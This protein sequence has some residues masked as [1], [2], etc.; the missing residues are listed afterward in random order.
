LH[1]TDGQIT[2]LFLDAVPREE[3]VDG[4]WAAYRAVGLDKTTVRKL[5][6]Q[7]L[8][9]S[10]AGNV[11][12]VVRG[13]AKV[14]LA[15]IIDGAIDVQ[16]EWLAAGIERPVELPEQSIEPVT[17]PIGDDETLEN[18][19][20]REYRGPLTPDMLRESLRRYKKGVVGGA[21]GFMGFSG[22]GRESMGGRMGGRKLFR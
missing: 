22:D 19:I 16:K 1:E 6:N 4:R 7:T 10:V 13:Y 20:A 9:Q 15:E 2:S 3:G 8:S 17:E 18:K 21:A 14:F 11:I 12:M 5:V